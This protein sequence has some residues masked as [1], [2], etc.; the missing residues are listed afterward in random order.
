MASGAPGSPP[1]A[2]VEG[3]L[4]LVEVHPDA[5]AVRDPDL[6]VAE[7]D[8]LDGDRVLEQQVPEELAALVDPRDRGEGLRIGR[9]ADG[10][11]Q[12]AAAVEPDTGGLRDRRDF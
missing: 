12:H 8:G 5:G 2:A 4:V 1:V 11:L 3:E 6:E 9:G 10:G 7:L